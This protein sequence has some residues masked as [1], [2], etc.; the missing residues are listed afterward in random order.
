MCPISF[1][2]LPSSALIKNEGKP[3]LLGS[4]EF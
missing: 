4:V 3:I 1:Y 2:T